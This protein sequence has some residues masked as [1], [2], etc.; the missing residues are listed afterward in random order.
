M[1]ILALQG[2]PRPKGNT[3]AVLDAV[4]SAAQGAGADVET[5][6]LSELTDLTGCQECF[7]CQS[8]T[9]EPGC[10][11]E[12]DMQAILNKVLEADATI[13][14]TPVFCW[15][16]SWLMKMAMDRLY[17]MFKFQESG[18]YKCLLAGRK[19]AV[20]VTAGGGKDEGADMIE[21][22]FK[23]LAQFSG[24]RWLGALLAPG[25]KTPETIRA[26]ADLL[27][28]ARVFGRQLAS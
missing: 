25:V 8:Q 14:A 18:D 3:Q 15:T 26:D 2:S 1:K 6:Q 24:G 21:E 4:L 11:V 5:V 27:E 16:P 22:I 23:R 12:D 9:D 17:C 19:M 13:W 10:I 28:R 20:V 7:G